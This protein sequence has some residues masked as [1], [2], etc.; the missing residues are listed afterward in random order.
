[1]SRVVLRLRRDQRTAPEQMG[2]ASIGQAHTD[3]HAA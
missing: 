1:V 3:P 2:C